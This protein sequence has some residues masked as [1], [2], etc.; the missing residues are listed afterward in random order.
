MRNLFFAC[1]ISL[2]SCF[3][4]A[5]SVQQNLSD[6]EQLLID[7]VERSL[8]FAGI[9]VSGLSS[10]VLQIEGMSSP[11]VRHLLNNLGSLPGTNYLEV[12]LWKGSTWIST[13]YGNDDTINSAI[14]IDSWDEIAPISFYENWQQFI[15]NSRGQL[16]E[17]NCFN[18]DKGVFKK[19]VNLFFYDAEFDI[20]KALTFFDDV[21]DDAFI[22]LVDDWNFQ[23]V[24]ETT[25]QGI[26]DL[27]Y[28]VLLEYILPAQ[29]IGDLDLWWNGLYLA[30]IRK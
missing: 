16:Y 10:Q 24:Q 23:Q 4:L 6:Q 11:K 22:L 8:S 26:Q 12:G 28:N 20:N 13:L 15:S 3:S 25:R 1:A 30:V 17:V 14:G 9:G 18:I 7:H 19:P 29:T 21:L 2:V 27:G 5:E